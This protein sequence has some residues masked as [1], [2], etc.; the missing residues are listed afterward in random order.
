MRSMIMMTKEEDFVRFAEA[1]GLPGSI[2]MWR[3][4][5]RNALLPQVTGLSLNMGNIVGGAL[6]TE[7][8]FSYLG[9]GYLL[10]QA[11]VSGDYLVIQGIT[12]FI[13]VGICAAMYIVDVIYPLIDPRIRYEGE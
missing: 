12:L 11:V 3:Y 2:I 9:M 8:I 4:C 13:T 7:I 1:K 5:F 10:Y 6:L